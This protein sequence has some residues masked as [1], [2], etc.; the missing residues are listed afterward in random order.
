MPP[1][2]TIIP[3]PSL[4]ESTPNDLY[5][6]TL[7]DP[8]KPS[9][10]LV[11]GFL[12]SRAQWRENLEGLSEFCRPVV[13]ELLGHGRSPTPDDLAPYKVA[14]YIDFFERLRRRLEIKQWFICGQSFG[15]G[16]TL[17][18]SAAHP[19]VVRG[20]V[21][22]NSISGL[23]PPDSKE[24]KAVM[25]ER[26]KALEAKG[27]QGIKELPFHILNAKRFPQR[28]F[29]EM[30]ADA[31]LLEPKGVVNAIKSTVPGLS[32]RQHFANNQT[33]TLMVNG[34]WEKSFQPL[35]DYAAIALKN[36][37]ICDLEGGHSINVEKAPEFNAAVKA[38]MEEL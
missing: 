26:L 12:S 36:L 35:R 18:Y 2:Q 15:A 13:I 22:T 11:H 1:S 19:E 33:P 34:R 21:F 5:V 27:K 8:D 31:E 38:F 16:L 32:A 17:H 3:E 28:T 20:Q 24:R 37:E 14:A 25:V 7:G 30:A 6:E 4:P 10:L 23:S 9:L 29:D